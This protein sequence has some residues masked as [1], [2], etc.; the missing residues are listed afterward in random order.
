[1]A[2]NVESSIQSVIKSI[3][4]V[5]SNR[6]LLLRSHKKNQRRRHI[7][8]GWIPLKTNEI[9]CETQFVLAPDILFEKLTFGCNF[10]CKFN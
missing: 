5:T 8:N 4:F 10:N 3:S 7:W 9:G 1:M 6:A 2:V